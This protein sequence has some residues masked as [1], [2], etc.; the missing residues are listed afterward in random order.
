[1]TVE[2]TEIEMLRQEVLIIK[3]TVL[4]LSHNIR[5][6]NI[7][8]GSQPTE[9][10]NVEAGWVERMVKS[11]LD[12]LEQVTLQSEVGPV[13]YDLRGV[14]AFDRMYKM[15][16]EHPELKLPDIDFEFGSDETVWAK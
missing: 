1:M 3:D 11:D 16:Q 15:G 6:L 2:I 5:C 9:L 7:R 13:T 8:Q 4:M 12:M 14:H 10:P